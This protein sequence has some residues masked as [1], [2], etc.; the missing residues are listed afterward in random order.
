MNRVRLTSIQALRGVAACMVLLYH[1]SYTLEEHYLVE[2]VRFRPFGFFVELGYA[3]VD[4]FFVISGFVM[5]VTCYDRLG[6]PRAV[7]SFLWRRATRIYPLYWLVT[8]AV[9]LLAWF[10]PSLATRSKDDLGHIF[11]SVVLWRQ[12]VFPIMGVGW[13]LSYEVFF[14]LVF[15]VLIACPRKLHL[16]LL[17]AWGG[18]TLLRFPGFSQENTQGTVSLLH[19]PFTASPLVLEFIGGC[20]IGWLIKLEITGWGRSAQAAGWAGVLLIGGVSR[21]FTEFDF[22]YGLLRLLTFGSCVG[23]IVYGSAAQESRGKFV[24]PAWLIKIGDASYSLYLTHVYVIYCIVI[25][26]KSPAKNLGYATATSLS[27][28]AFVTCLAVGQVTFQLVEKP[29]IECSR[30]GLKRS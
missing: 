24:I 19:L 30:L 22:E 14:Y 7:G 23:L 16:L 3:G 11:K 5:T 17:M 28:A 18:I 12:D 4:L 15:A 10:E 29:L 9:L 21:A 2:G 8:L 20:L 27:L 6:D 1:L 25:L 13:T 26:V